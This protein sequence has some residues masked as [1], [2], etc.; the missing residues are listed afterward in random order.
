MRAMKNLVEE[1]STLIEKKNEASETEIAIKALRD[2]DY[3]DKDAFFKM[4]E[5]LKG[6]AVASEKDE[7]AKKFLSAVSDALTTAAKS[8]LSEEASAEHDVLVE[9]VEAQ[10]KRGDGIVADIK[11]MTAEIGNLS[12][13]YWDKAKNSCSADE[14][15]WKMRGILDSAIFIEENLFGMKKALEV[16]I[17]GDGREISHLLPRIRGC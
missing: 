12:G 2:T 1:L 16:G 7:K 8:V 10:L 14:K 17:S 5:L 6:L 15:V 9:D 4:V 3:R 13:E 11:K